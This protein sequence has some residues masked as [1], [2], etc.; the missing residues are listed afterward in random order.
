MTLNYSADHRRSWTAVLPL[1]LLFLVGCSQEMRNQAYYE[2]LE[3]SSLFP[4]GKSARPLPAN[5]VARDGED[6]SDPYYSGMENGEPISTIPEPLSTGLLSR[7]QERFD[8]FCAP[9]HGLAGYGD[10]MIV[11]RGFPAPPSFHSE[12]LRQAPP[13]YYFDVISNGFG[14]MFEYGSRVPPEDRWAIIAYIRA[15]QLSQN[16]SVDNLSADEMTQLENGE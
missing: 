7:G 8:I 16:T 11:Q 2:P 1:L 12:R 10:G 3:A 4:D 5:V 14:L 6:L 15:L 13:G 9:C